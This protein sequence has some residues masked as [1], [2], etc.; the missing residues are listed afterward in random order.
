MLLPL[1]TLDLR[2]SLPVQA[3]EGVSVLTVQRVHLVLVSD[4]RVLELVQ[5]LL[6]ALRVISLQLLDLEPQ[7]LVLSDDLLLALSV[8]SRVTLH[9]HGGAGD[10][11][12][13]L[14]ALA[15]AILEQFLVHNHVLGQ[16][17]AHLQEEKFKNVDTGE[18][19][20]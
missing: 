4:V 5:P 19:K 15:L 7:R 17:I 20:F 13:Q 6:L 12:L 3:I 2:L 1:Q 9:L 18:K 10:V 14:L 8:V 16:V 11:N